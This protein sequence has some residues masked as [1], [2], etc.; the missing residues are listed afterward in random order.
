MPAH[1]RPHERAN[2]IL[3]EPRLLVL[4]LAFGVM[5]TIVVFVI[6]FS[7]AFFT[8]STS[9]AGSSVS[10]GQVKLGLSNTGELISGSGLEPG[11]TRTATLTVT[12]LYEKAK[13]TLGVANL[14]ETSPAGPQLAD[15]LNVTVREKSPGSVVRFSGKLRALTTAASLGTWGPGEARTL[16]IEVAWPAS[17]TNLLYADA[18]V[19]FDF[20]WRAESAVS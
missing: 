9:N 20:D 2:R 10:A 16:E 15:V 12:N 3:R 1:A 4:L 13:V 17:E 8:A 18:K 5:V 11:V 6:G 19:N 7:K 14:S